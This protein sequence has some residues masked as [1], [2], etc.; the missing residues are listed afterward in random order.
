MTDD[1]D[2]AD[3][4]PVN[5]PD[6]ARR[7]HGSHGHLAHVLG[8]DDDLPIDPDL[9]ADDP[10][11]PSPTHQP[12][13]RPVHR[14]R[15]DGL[16]AIFAGGGL[17]TLGRYELGLAWPTRAGHFPLAT[18]TVNTSGALLIGVLLVLILE[19]FPPNRYAR[20]FVVVGG[21]GG[22]TTMST[23]AMETVLLAK[24]DHPVVA[25]GYLVATLVAGMA[26]VAA[27]VTLGRAGLDR[28]SSAVA[29]AA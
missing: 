15:L 1:A 7:R 29:E 21:L 16:A 23:L 9:A 4:T 26:A 2:P 3:A 11:E 12:A 28:R 8:A 14:A 13:P 6:A 20:P 24:G 10:G 19:R 5:D 18:F 25:A 22:W 17:G 27:G